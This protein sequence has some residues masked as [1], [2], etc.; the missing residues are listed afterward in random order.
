M[1]RVTGVGAPK[2]FL[3]RASPPASRIAAVKRTS[4]VIFIGLMLSSSKGMKAF[5]VRVCVSLAVI[6]GIT[7]F[8]S[9]IF[10]Q[11]NVTTIAMTYLLATLAIATT[12]GLREAILASV[13]AMFSFNFFFLPPYYTLTIM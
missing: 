4:S 13:T 11:A 12:W 2:P 8:Y 7:S 5:I 10:T 1:P 6:A 3:T 9:R